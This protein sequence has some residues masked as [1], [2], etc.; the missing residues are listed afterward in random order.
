[1]GKGEDKGW[2]GAGREGADANLDGNRGCLHRFRVLRDLK[3]R[4]GK[5]VSP[6]KPRKCGRL[7]GGGSFWFLVLGF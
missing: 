7:D 2:G 1:M 5:I 4:M 3:R 6:G